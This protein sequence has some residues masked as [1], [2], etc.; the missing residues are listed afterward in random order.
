MR[1]SNGYIHMRNRARE[2]RTEMTPA[3][4]RMW[5]ALCQKRCHGMRF[6]RQKFVGQYILDFYCAEFRLGVE[7][8]GCI[9]DLPEVEER[10]RNREMALL[11]ECGIRLVRFTNEEVLTGKSDDFHQRIFT[12]RTT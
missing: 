4:F 10:D 2:M 12:S 7:V 3:E 5:Q 11:E 1:E 6:I 8:D 9:H